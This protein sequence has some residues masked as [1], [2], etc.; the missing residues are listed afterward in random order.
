MH[1][2]KIVC[3]LYTIFDKRKTLIDFVKYYKRYKSGL[4]HKLVICFK[5]FTFNEVAALRRYLK[6]VN[7][8]EFVDPGKT[9]DW[10][11][12]SYKRVSKFFFNNKSIKLLPINPSPP[13]TITLFLFFISV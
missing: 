4:N 11:F 2:H 12:G 7:Y 5:L 1:N 10:D 3:Y 8:I 6:D 9:N 13:V